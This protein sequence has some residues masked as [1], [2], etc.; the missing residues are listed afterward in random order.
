MIPGNVFANISGLSQEAADATTEVGI[1]EV[2][3]T[4]AIKIYNKY[5]SDL[6]GV[7]LSNA[8]GK[9]FFIQ[10]APCTNNRLFM[11]TFKTGVQLGNMDKKF[12]YTFTYKMKPTPVTI[13]LYRDTQSARNFI[14]VKRR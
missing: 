7:A 1:V 11:G 3:D 2:D 8:V 6:A 10:V 12:N 14:F 4:G 13:H 5:E 9:N